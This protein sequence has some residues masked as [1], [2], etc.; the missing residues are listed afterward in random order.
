MNE[1]K[2]FCAFCTTKELVRSSLVMSTKF[3][4]FSLLNIQMVTH[5]YILPVCSL[6]FTHVTRTMFDSLSL[7]YLTFFLFSFFWRN[8]Q[9]T[10]E[11]HEYLFNVQ[12]EQLLYFV[13]NPL[14]CVG[15]STFYLSCTTEK[16]YCVLK[17]KTEQILNSEF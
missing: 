17:M 3:L 5:F 16:V 9:N 4:V 13:L 15:A 11:T 6:L 14:N 8:I 10:E 1:K 2:V 12:C 7:Y